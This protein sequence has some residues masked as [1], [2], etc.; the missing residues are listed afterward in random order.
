MPVSYFSPTVTSG[1]PTKLSVGASPAWPGMLQ[2]VATSCTPQDD[3][4]LH[5]A[6]EFGTHLG[7][8]ASGAVPPPDS[9]S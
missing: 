5:Q 1:P 8:A 6:A 4:E 9:I 3:A 2:H 7:P